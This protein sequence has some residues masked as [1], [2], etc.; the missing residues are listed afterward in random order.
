MS[1]IGGP[2]DL[3]AMC[4]TLKGLL[5]EDL[6][7]VSSGG[8]GVVTVPEIDVANA[9]RRVR[10]LGVCFNFVDDDGS[11][12]LKSDVKQSW[13]VDDELTRRLFFQRQLNAFQKL[14]CNSKS[15]INTTYAFLCPTSS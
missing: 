9:D 2:A 3:E 6:E 11:M 13:K 12:A 5:D 1:N 8:F 10:G 4:V 15:R 14:D 7:A